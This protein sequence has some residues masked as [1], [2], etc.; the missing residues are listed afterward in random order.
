MTRFVSI[1]F[2]RQRAGSVRMVGMRIGMVAVTM[3][4]HV[5]M[6]MGVSLA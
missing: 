2:S 6:I 5:V 1:T 3:F 4:V